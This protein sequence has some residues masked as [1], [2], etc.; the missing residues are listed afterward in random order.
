VSERTKEDFLWFR[1]SL[2]A[3]HPERIIP[4]LRFQE[5]LTGTNL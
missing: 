1:K 3:L 2:V 5:D 4:P